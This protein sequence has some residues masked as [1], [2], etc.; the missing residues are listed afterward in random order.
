LHR[1]EVI[2]L[3]SC[4]YL[5]R[6]LNEPV[7]FVAFDQR[8]LDAACAEGVPVLARSSTRRPRA[9][10][11]R[12]PTHAEHAAETRT[13]GQR[14]C[15]R[16]MVRCGDEAVGANRGCASS[17]PKLVT[18]ACRLDLRTEDSRQN[19][20]TP[21]NSSKSDFCRTCSIGSATAKLQLTLAPLEPS[22]WIH[23]SLPTVPDEHAPT[24]IDAS[25]RT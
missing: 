17:P 21:A 10:G 6:H 13:S 24:S 7:P 3:A 12:N 16:T 5:Q 19:L 9:C 22:K 18:A 15:Q 20:G 8:L 1:T 25:D 14:C 11:F 4:V 23:W 2:Q